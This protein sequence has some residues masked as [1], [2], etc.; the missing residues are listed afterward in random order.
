LDT[1]IKTLLAGIAAA[2]LVLTGCEKGESHEGHDHDHGEHADHDG[3]SEPDGDSGQEDHEGHDEDGEHD[4]HGE[5]KS[6]GDV[7][8]AGTT[9]AITLGGEVSAGAELHVNAEHKDGDVPSAVR[10]WIGDEDGTGAVKSKAD[11][12]EGEFHG[13]VEV[14]AEQSEGASLWIE[15]ESADGER[16]KGSVALN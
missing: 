10:L 11:G 4:D 1:R 15:I 9:L 13:H 16:H 8:I 3:H 5:M 6:L 14:S 7:T 2:G 12:S